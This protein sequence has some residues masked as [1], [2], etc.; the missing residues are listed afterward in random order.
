MLADD[1]GAATMGMGT[2]AAP[3]TMTFLGHHSSPDATSTS[4]LDAAL[5]YAARGWHVFPLSPRSKVPMLDSSGQHDATTDVDK[6]R[7]WWT[8]TP[9][10]N[11]GLDLVRSK[12]W[13]LD[14]DTYAGDEHRLDAFVAQHG[15]PPDSLE[16]ISGSGDARH[17][18]FSAPVEPDGTFVRCRGLMGGIVVRACNYI[19]VAPSVHPSGGTYRW[20]PGRG[21][22][23]KE[24]ADLPNTWIAAVRKTTSVGAVGA[25]AAVDEPE[26]LRAIPHA[27]RLAR[28]RSHLE[29]ER[30]EVHPAHVRTDEDRKRV[31]SG[32]MFT[33]ACSAVRSYAITD[34]DAVL[35]AML[36]V[37]NAKCVPPYEPDK[38]A[39]AVAKAGAEGEKEW[40]EGLKPESVELEEL[41]VTSAI[42]A[43]AEL[44]VANA[45]AVSDK[46][47]DEASGAV[48]LATRYVRKYA[49]TS[50][51]VS[52]RRW[53]GDWYRWTR[54]RGAYA[55][56]SDE[57]LDR[58]LYRALGLGRRSEVSDVRYGLIAVDDVLIEDVELGTWIGTAPTDASSLDVAACTNGIVDLRSGALIAPT[59][60]YFATAALGV[61]YDPCA[62]SPTRWL[63]FLGELWPDDAESIA[64]LQ[65]W[66][67]YL[68]TADTRQQKMLLLVGPKRSGKGTIMR[69]ATELLGPESVAAPTLASLGS[70]F[71]LWPLIGKSAA[72]I[73]D[74]RLSGRA[75]VAQIVERL[76][77]LSGEDKITID[78]K[79]REPWT[80][81]LS[82]RISLVSNELPRFADASGAIASR[83][84]VLELAQSWLGREDTGLTDALREELP[85]ILLWAIDGW[86][87]LRQRGRFVQPSRSAETVAEMADLSS[88]IAAWLRE[89]CVVE[90]GRKVVCSEAY[91]A[92]RTWCAINGQKIESETTFGRDLK[93]ASGCERKQ[94]REGAARPRVYLGVG[95]IGPVVTVSPTVTG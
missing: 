5:A 94:I 66:L 19:V 86:R 51:G 87:R 13:A 42:Q 7:A 77:S 57:T 83:F 40:G 3:E 84:L 92:Y 16:Q 89:A 50:D 60:R 33:V 17:L 56:I 21:P 79:H 80:G 15:A 49:T 45:A 26:W 88:P 76:L 28:M 1:E 9:N 48:E 43:A 12:L 55:A 62:P 27:D 25:L 44:E 91:E 39:R 24:A 10:A 63:A 52:L 72:V 75:D 70:N 8:A 2:A 78:R 37:Y 59:P 58:D 68:L 6:I 46:G 81:K 35:D 95:L 73:G 4:L 71:G 23:E 38:I 85:G 54:E 82:T 67:G 34:L 36:E 11:I 64:A 65:E 18:I 29:R 47:D 41:G 74:A 32:T 30:G 90:R 61:A 93:A 14:V 69:V 31:R 22:D 53:R 20:R